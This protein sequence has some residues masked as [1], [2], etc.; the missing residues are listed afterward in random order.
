MDWKEYFKGFVFF[1][2]GIKAAKK[3]MWVSIQVLLA[4]TV[5][6]SVILYFVEHIAQPDV[7][8]NIW[9][10]F[11]WGL[12]SYLGNPGNF[13]PGEPITMVGRW[14]AI[15]VSIIKILIF[16]V[17]AGLVANGFRKAMADDKR[18]KQ[19]EK[20]RK[21]MRKAFRRRSNHT[22][23]EYLNTL[24]DGG[25]ERYARLNFVPSR[26]N[27]SQ[28]QVR[29]GMS[30]QDI[31]DTAIKFPEF[32]LKSLAAAKSI[33]GEV[34]DHFVVEMAPFN[35][36]YGCLIDRGSRVTIVSTS[37]FEEVGIS[38]FTYYLA[39][40]GGFNYISKEIDVDTDELDS[41]YNM[42]KDVVYEKKTIAQYD[43]N[44]KKNS[45]AIKVIQEKEKNR[46]A[47]LD[48]LSDLM[49]R[50]ESPWVIV[51]C[52]HIKNQDN[53][54][55]LHFACNNKKGDKSTIKDAE[56]Y[57]EL[58]SH[59]TKKMQELVHLESV[60]NLRYPLMKNNLLYRLQDSK[61]DFNGFVL[62][63][64]SELTTFNTNRLLVAYH[65]ANAI[66]DVLD[67]NAS[68]K[69]MDLEGFKPGFGYQE[70]DVDNQNI[71]IM[72]K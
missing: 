18:E 35:R 16:S 23:R 7:Y 14:I 65:A 69:E 72:D 27:V 60:E 45:T 5:V 30:L 34:N 53:T 4:A 12:M 50:S 71:Y 48:D 42:S 21:R 56:T 37:G 43:A 17:P 54:V 2:A 62:R 70:Q 28:M 29:Q 24:P 40:F 33:E 49:S 63:P 20:F 31:I 8:S 3:E 26:I 59:F 41:F 19:L 32:R 38:W 61:K 22:I 6:L 55:D 44:N 64:S 47:F 15:V 10:S 51:M 39:K 67:P 36:S 46:K 13:S 68:L 11:V 1:W 25:G 57:Q 9:D 52:E 66:S 58:F